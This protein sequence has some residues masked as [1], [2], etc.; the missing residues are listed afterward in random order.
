MEMT[1]GLLTETLGLV[2]TWKVFTF[3][4]VSKFAKY[5]CGHEKLREI[6]RKGQRL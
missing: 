6:P 3:C 5:V 2:K 1:N 4:S